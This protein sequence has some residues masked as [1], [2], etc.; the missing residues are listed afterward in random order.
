M[1]QAHTH[2]GYTFKQLWTK[3]DTSFGGRCKTFS[4]QP[5][6]LPPPLRGIDVQCWF[7]V[8]VKHFV[9]YIFWIFWDIF[10]FLSC[11]LNELMFICPSKWH[12]TG[13]RHR[14]YCRSNTVHLVRWKE[15]ADEKTGSPWYRLKLSPGAKDFE[16]G[17]VKAPT[18]GLAPNPGRDG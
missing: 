13:K 10:Y 14:N 1:R 9:N 8:L 18:E 2:S 12:L 7:L 11:F 16:K 17:I 15:L 6:H 3:T 4:V 5:W